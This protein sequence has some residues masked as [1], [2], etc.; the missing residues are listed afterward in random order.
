M[1]EIYTIGKLVYENTVLEIYANGK[2][3]I[4]W[5]KLV[6]FQGRCIQ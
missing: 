6:L 3:R 2:G 5:E 1:L 4:N